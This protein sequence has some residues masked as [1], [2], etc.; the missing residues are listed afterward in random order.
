MEAYYWN[1]AWVLL[2]SKTH[3][4]LGAPQQ[5]FNIGA[6]SGGWGPSKTVQ[7]AFDNYQLICNLPNTNTCMLL[8]LVD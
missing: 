1:G 3:A 5:Y 7:I 4:K 2:G 6:Y 8:L